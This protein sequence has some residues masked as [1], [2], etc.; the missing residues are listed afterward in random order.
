M[1][2]QRDNRLTILIMMMMTTWMVD[3]EEEAV[4]VVIA[5]D[6]RITSR[7]TCFAAFW[8]N[9]VIISS[10]EEEQDEELFDNVIVVVVCGGQ[11]SECSRRPA[12]TGKKVSPIVSVPV[13]VCLS[14]QQLDRVISPLIVK[15][16][17]LSLAD[18]GWPRGEAVDNNNRNNPLPQ[19][20]H[21]E[22]DLCELL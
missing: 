1:G 19:G 16:R 17:W 15:L 8:P 10:Q 22:R 11:V 13:S 20:T 2:L 4:A 12:C 21:E 7:S 9:P 14:G 5:L 6:K 3:V 18:C